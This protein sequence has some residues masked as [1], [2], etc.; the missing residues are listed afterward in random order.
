MAFSEEA[1][2]QTFGAIGDTW[3]RLNATTPDTTECVMMV[4]V[5]TVNMVAGDVLGWK[6]EEKAIAGSVVRIADSGELADAQ[7]RPL[8][9]ISLGHMKHGWDVYLRQRAGA[10]RA[11]PWSI[12]KVT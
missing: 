3:V 4:V 12:R 8:L 6:V 2:T 7:S 11:F 10:V 5:D 1:G 9:K